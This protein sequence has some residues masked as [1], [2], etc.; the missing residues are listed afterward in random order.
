MKR[1]VPVKPETELTNFVELL[2]MQNSFLGHK[3]MQEAV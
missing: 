2:L 3:K 1:L